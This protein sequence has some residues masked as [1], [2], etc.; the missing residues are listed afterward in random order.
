M[1]LKNVGKVPSTWH[2]LDKEKMKSRSPWLHFSALGGVLE[3][4]EVTN[5][6]MVFISF[7]T[8]FHCFMNLF[9]LLKWLSITATRLPIK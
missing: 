2:I 1:V 3:V 8:A 6:T 5:V 7:I 4:G 9:V